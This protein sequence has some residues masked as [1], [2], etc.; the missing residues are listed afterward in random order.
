MI[1]ER[2]ISTAARTKQPV[3]YD[4]IP[5]ECHKCKECRQFVPSAVDEESCRICDHDEGQHAQVIF[6]YILMYLIINQSY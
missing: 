1:L 6:N 4:V 3:N 5:R 2:E